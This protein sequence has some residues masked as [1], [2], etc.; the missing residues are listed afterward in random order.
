VNGDPHDQ[1]VFPYGYG[2]AA[3]AHLNVSGASDGVA[4][5]PDDGEDHAVAELGDLLGLVR[6]LVIGGEPLFEEAT[7]PFD[8]R[9]LDQLA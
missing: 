5:T 8:L 4:L 9:G 7:N 1:I 2:A 3:G 6:R